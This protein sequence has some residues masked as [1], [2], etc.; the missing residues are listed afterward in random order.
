MKRAAFCVLLVLVTSAC[1][2]SA[3]KGRPLPARFRPVALSALD[4]HDFLLLGTR[5]CPEGGRCYAI[6]RTADGGRTFTR[7]P[8]PKGLPT[9]GT[10]PTLRFANARDGFIWVPSDW[11]AFWSSHD[12]GASWRQ[13]A[14]PA[15]VAFTTAGGN[16]Y[17]VVAH[18]TPTGCSGYLFAQG[19]VAATRWS[20]VPLPFT[21]EGPVLD[22]TASGHDVW[23]LGT[24]HAGASQHDLLARSR[25]G[26]RTFA[27]GPGP[28]FPGLG[29][30]LRPSSP[31]VVWAV[32]PTGMMAGAAR[33]TN[34]GIT[35]TPLHT[36]PLINAAELAPA[37]D[38]TAILAGNGVGRP[39]YRTTDG[40]ASW[41]P[42]ARPGK[43][44]YWYDV[45]F[46]GDR[47]GEALVEIGGRNA[48]VWRT[49]DAGSSWAKVPTAA[50]K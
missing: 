20:K 29:G 3:P 11:G 32:C 8:A 41:Q 48:A 21:P 17:A 34:G 5:P 42:V 9:E 22:L 10:N 39:I 46:T 49:T 35:F 14:A 40:G 24:P 28:C 43:D 33:S 30:A 18:C 37:S 7:L 1:G 12:G 26:G 6:E 44:D 47:V 13:L 31:H 38:D 4:S 45:T 25:N 27:L 19:P 16:A 15:I 36:P 2:T 50:A 23:L